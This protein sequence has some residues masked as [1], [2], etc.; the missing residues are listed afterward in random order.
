MRR[1]CPD[2]RMLPSMS[3]VADRTRATSFT[4]SA[5]PPKRNEEVR[6]TTLMPG[7]RETAFRI[8]SLRPSQNEPS[9]RPSLMSTKGSTARASTGS[10]ATTLRVKR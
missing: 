9:V 2:L 3:S 10:A 6:E 1:F 8:S 4:S 7:M 5:E